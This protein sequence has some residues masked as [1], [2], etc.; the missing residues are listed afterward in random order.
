MSVARVACCACALCEFVVQGADEWFRRGDMDGYGVPDIR[1]YGPG[2][3]LPS[4]YAVRL[5]AWPVL[6]RLQGSTDIAPRIDEAPLN[7]SQDT[8]YLDNIH[9]CY[10]THMT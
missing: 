6:A 4:R 9:A 1:S 8:V 7:Q 2:T 5:T 3:S 10:F